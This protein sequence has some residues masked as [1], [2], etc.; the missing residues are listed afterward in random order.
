MQYQL[1]HCSLPVSQ[2][3]FSHNVCEVHTVP[4]IPTLGS[5]QH[6]SPANLRHP[7][8]LNQLAVLMYFL[9]DLSLVI[10][11]DLTLLPLLQKSGCSNTANPTQAVY[12]CSVYHAAFDRLIRDDVS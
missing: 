6:R 3:H 7:L 11:L 12:R 9:T 2:W 10:L 8:Q 1:W 4:C 5:H